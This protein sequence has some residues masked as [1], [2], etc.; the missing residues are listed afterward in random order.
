MTQYE[1]FQKEYNDILDLVERDIDEAINRMEDMI[2]TE[3]HLLQNCRD[4]NE[5]IYHEHNLCLLQADLTIM[6]DTKQQKLEKLGRIRESAKNKL[7]SLKNELNSITNRKEIT[8]SRVSIK[9]P[10]KTLALAFAV[11]V[12]I[13]FICAKLQENG[14]VVEQMEA[15]GFFEQL[16]TSIHQFLRSCG[17]WISSQLITLGFNIHDYLDFSNDIII[18]VVY[19]A[20]PYVVGMLVYAILEFVS[21]LVKYVVLVLAKALRKH[22][23]RSIKRKM[24]KLSQAAANA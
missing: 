4:A 20:I 15:S 19:P 10:V 17:E 23:E 22:Q 3:S 24:R 11:S 1:R 8:V 9:G 13:F 2:V 6:K 16:Y 5:K 14:Y 7:D 12:F 21:S 18:S